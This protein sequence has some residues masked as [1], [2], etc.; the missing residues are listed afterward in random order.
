MKTVWK[1]GRP[2]TKTAPKGKSTLYELA[3][4][5]L[6]LEREPNKNGE[7]SPVPSAII[8]KERLSNTSIVNGEPV[9]QPMLPPRLHVAT[10]KA[11]REYILNPPNYDKLKGFE[12]IKEKALTEEERLELQR[13]VAA[14][15]RAAHEAQL[16]AIKAT[17]RAEA[18]KAMARDRLRPNPESAHEVRAA[19]EVVAE[20]KAE[21]A[22]EQEAQVNQ[23]DQGAGEVSQSVT[24][25]EATLFVQ[26]AEKNGLLDRVRKGIC[27]TL[28]GRGIDCAVSDAGPSQLTREE[29]EK[30]HTALQRMVQ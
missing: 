12:K 10:P 17:E 30:F 29:F 27:A 14:E 7:I 23:D 24:Q 9:I 26:L 25:E 11:I 5:Y 20:A 16:E 13:D 22:Q 28:K 21:E 2:T 4:L 15:Q 18:A 6:Q 3:S 8:L 19:R 1:D